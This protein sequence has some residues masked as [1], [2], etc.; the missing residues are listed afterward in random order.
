MVPSTRKKPSAMTMSPAKLT[1]LASGRTA[2]L[3]DL[4]G[5][6][7]DSVLPA[8]LAW[9]EAIESVGIDLAVWN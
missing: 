8:V 6:L 1:K 7:V 5:T 9:R 3:F 4:N 2:F